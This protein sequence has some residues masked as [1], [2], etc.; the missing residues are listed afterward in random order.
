MQNITNLIIL[1]FLLLFAGC[2]PD[3][4]ES[5]ENNVQISSDETYFKFHINGNPYHF[6]QISYE[7]ARST[8][9]VPINDIGWQN[10]NYFIV[11][12]G[13]P[14]YP[15]DSSDLVN[16]QLGDSTF[17]NDIDGAPCENDESCALSMAVATGIPELSDLY[18]I[19]RN[20]DHS[21]F[22]KV[23]SVEYLGRNSLDNPI[24]KIQGVA[25]IPAAQS[26]G[27]FIN[28]IPL[29]S[30]SYCFVVNKYS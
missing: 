29:D 26:Q 13:N 6:R 8:E 25:R 24:F 19:A 22:N 1:S 16:L 20:N 5:I 9:W 2:F 15:A 18:V 27:G 12:W 28:I 7:A 23:T 17:F 4:A 10:G 14:I 30:V 3:E 11:V 21:F